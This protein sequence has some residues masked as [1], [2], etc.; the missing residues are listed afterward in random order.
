[1][2]IIKPLLKNSNNVIH[3]WYKF[4]LLILLSKEY[5]FK[6]DKHFIAKINRKKYVVFMI[7]MPNLYHHSAP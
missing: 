4:N 1:M 2:D 6:H 3:L 7:S 5:K